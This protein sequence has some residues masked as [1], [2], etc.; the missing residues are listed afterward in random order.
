MRATDEFGIVPTS[1]ATGIV[2]LSADLSPIQVIGTQAIRQ[3]M[4]HSCI[5][6]AIAARQ[7]PGVSQLVLNPDDHYGHG[8]PVGSVLVSPTHIYPGPVGV[9]IKCSMSLLQTD[10]PAEAIA[11]VEVRRKL[12]RE[13]ESRLGGRKA[14]RNRR[15]NDETVFKLRFEG[16]SKSLLQEL[17]IPTEWIERCEDC[18]P[19]TTQRSR[20]SAG[21]S[22]GETGPQWRHQEFA[23]VQPSTR[24]VWR[25][26]SFW[27]MRSGSCERQ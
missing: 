1:E 16:A 22:A 13:I 4:G 25:W 12:I 26:Q 7:A 9:D 23:R 24:L 21:Y 8:V 27:R 3:S 14:A 20:R 17:D 6:Q 2:P 19:Y 5:N 18:Q 11:D 10:V 15:V